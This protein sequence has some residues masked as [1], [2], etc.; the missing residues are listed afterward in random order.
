VV[1]DVSWIDT[2]C[3]QAASSLADPTSSDLSELC[4]RGARR[5]L[6]SGMSERRTEDPCGS[7]ATPAVMRAMGVRTDPWPSAV[8]IDT[9]TMPT[10]GSASRASRF[11]PVP[12]GVPE[13]Q[14]HFRDKGRSAIE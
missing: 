6:G 5:R 8:T 1:L 10:E 3:R 7:E 13:I 2:S 9:A 14:M 4:C 12:F 11:P